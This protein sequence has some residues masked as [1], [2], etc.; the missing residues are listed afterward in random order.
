MKYIKTWSAIAIVISLASCNKFLDTK[1]DGQIVTLDE[2]IANTEDAKLVLNGAYDVMGNVFDGDIQSMA[3]LISSN[4]G[5]PNSDDWRAVWSRETT[6]FNSTINGHYTDVYRVINRANLVLEFIDRQ[7]E[8]AELIQMKAEAQF[9]RGM[10]HFAVLKVYAQPWGYT[11]NNSHDGIVIRNTPSSEPKGRSTVA[12]CYSFIQGDLFQA[13][14]N[15]PVQNGIYATKYAASS[16]LA[17]TYY[18]QNNYQKVVEYT[19]EIIESGLYSLA[20]DVDVFYALNDSAMIYNTPEGIFF[21]H[22]NA[23]LSD[24]RNDG[25]RNNYMPGTSPTSFSLSLEFL[26]FMQ[27]NTTDKRYQVLV[28]NNSN[29]GQV[30]SLRFGKSNQNNPFFSVPLTR[31]TVMMLIRAEAYANLNTNLDVAIADINALRDRA[32]P[33]TPFH[34]AE[35]TTGQDLITIIQEEFRKET[36]CEGLWIDVERRN[37]VAGENVLIRDAPWNCPGMALQFP[38]SEGTGADFVFNPEGGCN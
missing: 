37:G 6:F 32:F 10:A 7:T 12:D 31:L 38:N 35:G 29:T 33:D 34:V 18:L 25:F 9:L 8:T 5:R 4:A 30:Q 11:S 13:Y 16:I 26:Q 36:F 22:S 2:F 24:A 3:E 27:F 17:Y 19:T 28:Q 23:D 20:P 21:A 14:S 1:S 15:L